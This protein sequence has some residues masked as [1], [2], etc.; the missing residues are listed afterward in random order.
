MRQKELTLDLKE[1]P[2][3]YLSSKGEANIGLHLFSTGG[4]LDDSWY[5]RTFW[6]YA[7]RWPGF[8]LANQSSKSGQLIVFDDEKTYALRVFYVR[9]VHSPM[10]H[11]GKQGYLLFADKNTNEPQI[12]GEPGAKPPVEWLPMSKYWW[13][14]KIVDLDFRSFGGDKM[15]GYTRNEPPLWKTWVKVRIRAMV[16]TADTLFA[17]GPPDLFDKKDPYAPF[18]GRRG[19]RLLA[20]DPADGTVMNEIELTSPPV[21]DGLIAVE[22]RLLMSTTDGKVVSFRAE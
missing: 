6:M 10:F 1:V 20:A 2:S 13:G 18:E 11:P 21:F 17:A 9:N 16:K 15:V 5:N 4:L 12:V 19:A 7:K 8:Q 22:N 14:K 3:S